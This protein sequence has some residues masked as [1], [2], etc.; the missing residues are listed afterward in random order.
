MS[1]AD[2]DS[3][4]LVVS[5]IAL[6]AVALATITWVLITD[7]LSGPRRLLAVYLHRLNVDL[8]FVRARSSSTRFVLAQLAVAIALTALGVV[9]DSRAFYGVPIALL[10]PPVLLRR[11]T[12]KRRDTIVEQLPPWLILLAN[13]LR[14]SGSL[15]DALAMTVPLTSKP[16]R[17]ELARASKEISLGQ[18]VDVAL[19]SMVSRINRPVFGAA[20]TTLLIARR[21]GGDLPRLLEQ[22]AA[23]IR[24]I[25]RLEGV[26][27][28]KTAQSKMQLVA[29]AAFPPLMY[30]ALRMADPLFF[31]ALVGLTG[32]VVYGISAALWAS[33]LLLARKFLSVDV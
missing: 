7:P 8:D 15:T 17:E 2:L 16:I 28:S 31:E 30:Y 10:L 11:Q 4:V 23:T 32:V 18:M 24:E 33:A 12:K 27:R 25:A 14:T 6:I 9:L 5:G 3:S 26:V 20:V 19:T 21:T 13:M 22:V 29:M 1:P